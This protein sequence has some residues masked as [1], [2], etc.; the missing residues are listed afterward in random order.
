MLELIANLLG[1]I[2]TFTLGMV[3]ITD[4]LKNL[5]GNSLKE[6]LKKFTGGT[7]SSIVTGIISTTILQS[8]H[9]TIL[10]TIGFVSAGILSFKQSIGIILGANLG[11]TST[12]WIVSLVGFKL[13][14]GK[15][16]FPLIGIGAMLKL[17]FKRKLGEFGLFLAGFSLLFL[18][19][20]FLQTAMR[21]FSQNFN[22]SN[23]PTNTL[24]NK[25]W[26]VLSGIGMTIVMQSSSAALTTTLSALSENVIHLEQACYLVIGQNIGTTLTAGIA[27]IGAGIPAKRTALVHVLF[28][29]LAAI[30]AFIIL[31]PLLIGMNKLLDYWDM[32]D[33]VSITVVFHSVF[34]LIGILVFLPFLS[35]FSQKIIELFPEEK[36]DPTRYL[37]IILYNS[38]SIA[39]DTLERSLFELLKM[40]LKSIEKIFQSQ[41][42]LHEIH[43]EAV[44]YKEKLKQIILFSEKIPVSQVSEKEQ[45][46]KNSLLHIIDHLDSLLD[47]ILIHQI[48]IFEYSKINIELLK[49]EL[50]ETTNKILESDLKNLPLEYIESRSKDLAEFRKS[51]RL[52]ILSTTAEG[53]IKASE[54]IR[55]IDMVRWFDR[56]HY[57][58]WRLTYHFCL[59]H[60]QEKSKIIPQ[61]NYTSFFLNK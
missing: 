23:I 34:N 55:E 56:V 19:I 45:E 17:L 2:G 40:I 13:S 1:G 44:K 49:K 16:A 11:T 33:P 51:T 29:I 60:V 35:W 59:N 54:A 41:V 9:A 20:D 50:L 10:T 15:L 30:V 4:S 6:A 61:K 5:A 37:D 32:D 38:P 39:L 24:F 48:S 57:Y 31:H 18:G 42:D 36:E 3:L 43:N 12:G 25:I 27:A 21:G 58:L 46:L 26:I 52:K 53:N 8:S 14:M 22:P 47:T 7:F 28:N